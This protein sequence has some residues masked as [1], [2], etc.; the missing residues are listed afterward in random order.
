MKAVIQRVRT[1]SVEIDNKIHAQIGP[2]YLIFLGIAKGDDLPKAEQLAQKIAALRVF[3][4]DQGKMNR[5]LNEINGE[6]LV[7]SQFTLCADLYKGNR[8]SFD[9][10]APPD[11]ARKIYQHFVEALNN[12]I[13]HKPVRTGVFGARMQVKI[14]NDGPVTFVYEMES[15]ISNTG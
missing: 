13:T 7:V 11:T 1:A 4:D 12:L 8:P 3:E 2:G 10:A 14:Q 9:K 15:V 5:S 6:A